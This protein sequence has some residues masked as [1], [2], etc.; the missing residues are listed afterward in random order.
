MN[1]QK[2]LL[3]IVLLS[4]T[5]CQ[6]SNIKAQ[7][8]ESRDRYVKEFQA[9]LEKLELVRQNILESYLKPKSL[10][11]WIKMVH[12]KFNEHF[13]PTEDMVGHVVKIRL[14]LDDNG[15]LVSAKQISSTHDGLA[16]IA[17]NAIEKAAPFPVDGLSDSEKKIAKSVLLNFSP[18]DTPVLKMKR[19]LRSKK[20]TN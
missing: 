10:D 5:A 4:L 11:V 15:Y 14:T 9:N 2:V 6:T 20:L 12:Y 18:E 16:E 19:E 17:R 8:A 7:Q 1:I 3:L 13:S